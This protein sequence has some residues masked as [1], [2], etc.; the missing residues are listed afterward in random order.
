MIFWS[1]QQVLS[2]MFSRFSKYFVSKSTASEACFAETGASVLPTSS[3]SFSG[4]SSAAVTYAT[5]FPLVRAT[6]MITS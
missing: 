1:T 4:K 2:V 6:L 3:S 5:T